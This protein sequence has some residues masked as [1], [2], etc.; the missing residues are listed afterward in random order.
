MKRF[1]PLLCLLL[2]LALTLSGCIVIPRSRNFDIPAEQ[3]ASVDIYDLRSLGFDP[4]TGFHNEI[5]PVWTIPPESLETF[6]RDFAALEFSDPLLIVLG[7][8]D[9][10]FFYG[11]WV[12]RVNYTDGAYTFFSC[13]GFGE[14]FDATGEHLG[15][16]HYSADDEEL[17][18][19]LLQYYTP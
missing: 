17:E 13:G 11:D 3:V 18:A 6:L 16:F 8:V 15:S 14:T 12:V 5:S 19:L 9:P 7:A 10:S 2:I 4:G 1:H